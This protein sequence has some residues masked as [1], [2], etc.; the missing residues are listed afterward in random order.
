[1][2]LKTQIVLVLV[3]VIAI[4]ALGL[5]LQQIRAIR[6]SIGEEIETAGD[7]GTQVLSRVNEIY[8]NQGA[9]SMQRFLTRLG[10][11]RAHDILLLDEYGVA[12][13]RTPASTYLEDLSVPDW[14]VSVV[15]PEVTEREFLLSNAKLIVRT[16]GSRAILEGWQEFRFL[17]SAI[18]LG[19]AL[20]S[21]FAWWLVGRAMRP[22]NQVNA[23]LRAV[24]D[25]DYSVRLPDLPGGEARAVGNSFNSMVG[26]LES[27]IAAREAEALAR[28]ELRKSR[29]LTQTIQKQIENE[30]RSLAQELHDELGQHVTAIKSMAVSMSRRL[31]DQNQGLSQAAE[32]I[33]DSADGIH[34]AIRQMLTQLRPTSLDKFGLVDAV[35]DLV[36]DWRVKHPDKRFLLSSEKMPETIEPEIRT[37]A[38]RIA[39]EALNNAVRHSGANRIEVRLE[40]SADSILLEVED[41]GSGFSA[42]AEREGFGITGMEERAASVSG[43]L[44]IASVSPTGS[45]VRATLPIHSEQNSLRGD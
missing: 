21:L 14:F 6:V 13:Y 10:R 36:S 22:F 5:A 9:R 4:L 20:L 43:V 2:K 27:S 30:H 45:L 37:T 31:A 15:S 24:G 19:F 8:Q 44:D 38:Y 35:A 11:L 29:E 18:I 26:N 40:T 12:I 33:A 34:A 1:M 16:D 3:F 39:Q 25:G 17:L 23:A 32:L 7:I 28:A 42:D 41:N